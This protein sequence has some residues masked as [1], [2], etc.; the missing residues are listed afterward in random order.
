[1]NIKNLKE[2]IQQKVFRED[3]FYRLNVFPIDV[4]P[5]RERPEDIAPLLYHFLKRFT[6]EFNKRTREISKE[7]LDLLRRYRWPG[8]VRELRNVV[9]RMCIMYNTE[10]LTRD[11]LPREI[12]GEGWQG[13]ATLDL[14]IPPGGIFLE[15]VLGQVE[16]DLIAKALLLTEGNVAQTAR[17]LNVPRGTLRYKLEKYALEGHG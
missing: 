9:E 11:H 16:R 8:N 15:D 2:A 6:R 7:A 12:W 10:T 13:E 14:D 1:M 17:L 4:P 5:L 3:L